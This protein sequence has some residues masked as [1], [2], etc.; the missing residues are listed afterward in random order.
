M[1]SALK[2][3]KRK[4]LWVMG[5]VVASFFIYLVAREL[6]WNSVLIEFNN[7]SLFWLVAAGVSN[8]FIMVLGTTQWI[9]FLP[10]GY[11]VRF[12]N[13]LE[14]N[15]LMTMTSNTIPFLAGQALAVLLLAKREKVGHAV[16]LSVMALDQFIAI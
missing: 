3:K 5:W 2:S 7:V 1:T 13:M 4:W 6:Q 8:L 10:R 16:A 15:A 12:K 11:H 14:V 9:N